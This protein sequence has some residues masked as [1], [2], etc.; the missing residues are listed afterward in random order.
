MPL[1]P[2]RACSRGAARTHELLGHDV[3]SH[4]GRRP[5][6]RCRRRSPQSHGAAVVA[7]FP[8]GA[9]PQQLHGQRRPQGHGAAVAVAVDARHTP[10]PPSAPGAP[11]APT[12]PSPPSAESA[13]PR[14]RRPREA[15]VSTDAGAAGAGGGTPQ[16]AAERLAPR[17]HG[18]SQAHGNG[19]CG[20]TAGD[21]GPRW[22][23]W[24]RPRPATLPRGRPPPPP[25]PH[26]R[27]LSPPPPT[28]RLPH[29]RR[30]PPRSR[31]LPG[32][33]RG[34]TPNGGDTPRPRTTRPP[35]SPPARPAR[36]PT[37]T[38]AD[39]AADSTA[40][41]RPTPRPTTCR[42]R[43]PTSPPPSKNG[44]VAPHGGSTRR[45]TADYPPPSPTARPRPIPPRPPLLGE[46]CNKMDHCTALGGG[47]RKGR[48]Q[49][50]QPLMRWRS[51][52]GG[53]RA[54]HG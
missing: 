51:V 24:P 49:T 8:R 47:V 7:A 29:L 52:Q 10:A 46:L 53:T 36:P 16:T 20:A 21:H 28:P 4:R 22:R 39:P 25:R 3:A 1:P 44:R 45:P 26:P 6:C 23:P 38:R 18:R 9:R 50:T 12:S 27:L 41:P 13:S 31:R 54:D 34:Q 14:Q 17:P 43:G 11:A 32:V 5:R 15:L 48:G 2:R 33:S 35:I 40:P 30:R 19:D 42:P 37:H